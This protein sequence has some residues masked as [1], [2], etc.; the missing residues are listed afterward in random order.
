MELTV[1]NKRVLLDKPCTLDELLK[2][3][4]ITSMKGVAVA[5]NQHVVR[6]TDLSQTTLKD[7]DSILVIRATQGG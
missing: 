3:M 6:K 2:D 1:N 4:E 7:H 5:V